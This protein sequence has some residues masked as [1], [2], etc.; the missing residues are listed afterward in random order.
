MDEPGSV[1]TSAGFLISLILYGTA[2]KTPPSVR[3]SIRPHSAFRFIG[4]AFTLFFQ[5]MA[6][7]LN[8]FHHRGEGIKWGL[9]SYTVVV[10]SLVTIFTAMNLND[11]LVE[12][13]RLDSESDTP[14]DS[15]FEVPPP[16]LTLIFLLNY[17]LSAGFLVGSFFCAPFVHPGV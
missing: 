7:L 15:G 4:I 14:D 12:Y 2:C 17:W 5:S 9:V 1:V 8:P 6:A 10:F 13:M 11:R 16:I 3:R